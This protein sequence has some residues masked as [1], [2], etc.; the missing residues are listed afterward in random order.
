MLSRLFLNATQR[1]LVLLLKPGLSSFLVV[2]QDEAN[3][4][5]MIAGDELMN[6]G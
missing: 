3:I 6:W 5:T 2:L 4:L 1:D